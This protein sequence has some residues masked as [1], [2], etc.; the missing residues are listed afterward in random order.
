MAPRE[1]RGNNVFGMTGCRGG[2]LG[3]PRTG[4]ETPEA[5][6]DRPR[7]KPQ[8]RDQE[9]ENHMAR[10]CGGNH[11]AGGGLSPPPPEEEWVQDVHGQWFQIRGPLPS[12]GSRHKGGDGYAHQGDSHWGNYRR[13]DRDKSHQPSQSGSSQT[14]G[15]TGGQ[16][17][18]T[19]TD[20]NQH[21]SNTW[22]GGNPSTPVGRW[23]R[24]DYGD[25]EWWEKPDT[26][27]TTTATSPEEDEPDRMD[28]M[29]RGSPSS[30]PAFAHP[31]DV[32]A[33]AEGAEEAPR[34]GVWKTILGN[35][36]R[37]HRWKQGVPKSDLRTLLQYVE[38][39]MRGRSL[40]VHRRGKRWHVDW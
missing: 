1:W 18:G 20:G 40:K 7:R 14:W 11:T 9:W 33:L 13:G 23:W 17:D 15:H 4:G 31:S 28:L 26:T 30:R 39:D 35:I 25:W 24:N 27:T 19:W 22:G 6:R 2:M 38:E 21:W 29:Q 10:L 37:N 32:H 16:S 5:D 34:R 12:G 36:L 3:A 8:R